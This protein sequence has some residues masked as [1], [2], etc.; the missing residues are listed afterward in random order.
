MTFSNTA[1]VCVVGEIR[2]RQELVL[3]KRDKR[4]KR[5]ERSEK[6]TSL[7]FFSSLAEKKS[8]SFRETFLCMIKSFLNFTPPIQEQ[9]KK[10][11]R[12]R[13]KRNAR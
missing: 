2:G 8:V 13:R 11:K 6:E 10:D 7:S 1:K 4:K 3:K 12:K 5:D 9:T